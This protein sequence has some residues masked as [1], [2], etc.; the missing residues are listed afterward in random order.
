[1]SL[2]TLIFIPTF[3]SY[4]RKLQKTVAFQTEKLP[5]KSETVYQ[6]PKKLLLRCSLRSNAAKN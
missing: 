6:E 4:F 3:V 5:Q 2:N 1:M